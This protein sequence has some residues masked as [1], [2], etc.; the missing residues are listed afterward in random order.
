VNVALYVWRVAPRQVPTLL[1]RLLRDRNRLRRTGKV[2]FMKVLGTGRNGQFGPGSSDPTRWAALVVGD[3]GD[4]LPEPGCRLDLRL[5][6]SR[7]RWSGREPFGST[8]RDTGEDIDGVVL[9]LT[10]A[11]LRPTRAR[12]FWRAISA[13]AVAAERATGLHAAFG[14]GEAPIG[15]QGTVT[16]WRSSRDLVEF[17][18]RHP[19]HRQVVDGTPAQRWYAEE[20]FARFAVVGLAGDRSVIGWRA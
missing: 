16:V 20:L 4:R 12:R 17:A 6:N 13:P 18:Y 14:I 3:P 19:A 2:S 11:R 9:A 5:L 1:V 7:G 8:K 15:W 10:R